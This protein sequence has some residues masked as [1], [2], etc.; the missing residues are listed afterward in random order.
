[1]TD[2]TY[3]GPVPGPDFSFQDPKEASPEWI[4]D[5]ICHYLLQALEDTEQLETPKGRLLYTTLSQ[6]VDL[7]Y[8]SSH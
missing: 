3:P 4:A 6:M 7:T 2:K 1:M 8:G 5:A